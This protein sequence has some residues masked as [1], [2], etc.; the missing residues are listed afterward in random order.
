MMEAE[1]LHYQRPWRLA[2]V[3]ATLGVVLSVPLYLLAHKLHGSRESAPTAALYVGSESCG[4]CHKKEF[5]AWKVSNHALAMLAPRPGTVLGNFDDATFEENGQVTR[6]TRKGSQYW[7]HTPGPGGVPGDYEIAYTFGWFPLQQ[8]LVAFPGGRLQCLSIAWDVEKRQWFS[9]YPGQ[10]VPPHDWLYWTRPAMNWNTMCSQCHSTGVQ[11]RYDPAADT[12]QTTWSEISVGCEACHGPGSLHAVWG[13]KPAMARPKVENALLTV[14]T[15]NMAQKDVVDLCMSCHSRRAELKDLVHPGGEPLDALLPTL[16]SPGLYYPDG[17]ILDED[18]EYQ[19]FLQSKM[20]EKGVKCNDCHDVHRA[21][22][23]KEGNDLCLKCHRADT[24]DTESHHFHK[25][26][27]DGKPSE[28]A[29]CPACHMPGRNYMVVH[30][31]RDHSIRVPRPDLS[32]QLGT[33]NACTQSGCHADKPLSW[34]VNAYNKW[35][36]EK[37]KPHY[38]TVI[39]AAREHKP[40][41]RADLLALAS[42]PL[43]PAIVRATAM[44]LL[45][46]YP[47]EDTAK[48]LQQALM[49]E[50]A[51]IRRTAANHLPASDPKQLAKYLVPMLKDPVLGVRIEAASRLAGLPPELL[52]E[53]QTKDFKAAMEEYRQ[54]LDFAADMPSG[55]YNMGILAQTLGESQEAEKQY[56]KALEFDDQFYMAQVNLALLLNQQGR[57]AEAETLL[58]RALKVRPQDPNISFN[59]GLLLAEEGKGTEAEEALRIALQADPSMAQAAYNLA[60]LL[61]ARQ[62]AEAVD[63]CRRATELR[64]EDPKYA[65]TYAYFQIQ[66]RDTAGAHRT[67]EALLRSHPAYGDGYMLLGDLL[68]KEGK[69]QE[70]AALYERALTVKELADE[71]RAQIRSRLGAVRK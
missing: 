23:Y 15:S 35:Y 34:S 60:V 58:L 71:A 10:N 44:D 49:D 41:A 22:R 59:L 25:K 21:R 70:A 66:A 17:Q 38:G 20:F 43:R 51:L 69:A 53:T 7:V 26:V 8:Y 32:E 33:P 5:D 50:D 18:Y 42:D 37:R 57:N 55:R 12:F 9:L 63:L 27:V 61:A 4:E 24:Y 13:K 2:G 45:W 1:S 56:K 11:K 31:R 16:L 62:P 52:T 19:S 40:Q 64:P 48:I 6:F 46:A 68:V 14:K 29:S 39:A 54:S 47:G 28:G 67:L 3:I 36:G 30:F 65:F